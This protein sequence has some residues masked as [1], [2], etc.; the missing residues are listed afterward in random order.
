MESALAVLTG[1]EFQASWQNEIAPRLSAVAFDAF[2]FRKET[3]AP[4]GLIAWRQGETLI[5]SAR[6]TLTAGAKTYM[7]QLRHFN[8]HFGAFANRYLDGVLMGQTAPGSYIVTAFA[9]VEES[10]PLNSRSEGKLG[11]EGIDQAASRSISLAVVGALSATA[12]ALDHYRQAGSLSGFEV[13][14]ARG[15]SY[16]M[17]SA[18][19][20]IASHAEVADVQVEWDP[21]AEPP[22]GQPSRVELEL[23]GADYDVLER[24]SVRLATSAPAKQVIAFGRVH[25][26]TKKQAGGPG[27]VGITTVDGIPA[28]TVRVHLDSDDYHLAVEAHD[29]DRGVRVSG[30]VEREGNLHWMYHARI[31]AV[32]DLPQPGAKKP[33]SA[34]LPGQVGL[35]DEK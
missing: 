21:S 12:E 20:R 10:V 8:N 24:A 16:E 5:E 29:Q 33:A 31:T 23:T 4:T 17:T 30:D 25:L 14:I 11:I 18:L 13:G 1:P 35:P 26:L 3:A 34:E 15:V 32:G 27:V 9:P 2:R 19:K 28:P 7:G 22:S 6:S